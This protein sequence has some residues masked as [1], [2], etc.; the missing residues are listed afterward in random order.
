MQSMR[1]RSYLRDGDEAMSPSQWLMAF[2][3]LLFILAGVVD[4]IENQNLKV[5]IALICIGVANSL[6]LWGATE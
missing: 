2:A 3:C 5:S 1:V 4:F 6:L